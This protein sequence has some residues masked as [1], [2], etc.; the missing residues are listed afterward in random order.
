M[1]T[2]E[3]LKEAVQLVGKLTEQKAELQRLLRL[4]AK[5]ADPLL[6]SK[7]NQAIAEALKF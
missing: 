3:R 4:A 6:N 7:Q 1:T 2:D 5:K